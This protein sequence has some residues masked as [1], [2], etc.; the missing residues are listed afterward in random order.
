MIQMIIY[1]VVGL[2]HVFNMSR[3][4]LPSIY[5][6]TS[7][8]CEC[9]LGSHEFGS[10]FVLDQITRLSV[11]SNALVPRHPNNG[12]LARCGQALGTVPD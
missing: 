1:C 12:Y 7:Q 4:I 2:E 3:V 11:A 9:G 5:E 10:K 8:S 6:A